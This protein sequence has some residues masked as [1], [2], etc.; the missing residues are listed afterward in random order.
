MNTQNVEGAPEKFDYLFKIVLVGDSGV[1]K[2]NLL[3]QLTRQEFS[4]SSPPTI[5][6]EFATISF[7]IGHHVVKA[8]IWDT[9]G[10]ERYRAITSAYYRG[11]YGALV[12]Y[13]ITRRATLSQSVNHWLMQLRQY[14]RKN[15][16]IILVGNKKDLEPQRE[17]S[18]EEGKRLAEQNGFAI[19]ET[20]ALSGENVRRVF[21]ELVR[22]IYEKNKLTDAVNSKNNFGIEDEKTK[23]IKKSRPKKSG[24]CC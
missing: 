18:V 14:S 19:F 8:Q 10:Q 1:G 2:T 22:D 7:K 12:V 5:G 15:T 6:V 11:T 3:S 4:T 9:A 13:D 23:P 20:S 21:F 17:V 16:T 24:G